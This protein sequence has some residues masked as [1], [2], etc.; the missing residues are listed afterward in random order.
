MVLGLGESRYAGVEG[1]SSSFSPG[2]DASLCAS[3]SLSGARGVDG[4]VCL[5][6][7]PLLQLLVLLSENSSSWPGLIP[8][9]LVMTTKPLARIVSR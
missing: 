1:G 3:L 6:V 7:P 5:F 2:S 4:Y 8:Q 9:G